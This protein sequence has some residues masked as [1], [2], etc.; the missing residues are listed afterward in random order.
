MAVNKKTDSKAAS[1]STLRG[2]RPVDP[3]TGDTSHGSNAIPYGRFRM[4]RRVDPKTGKPSDEPGTIPYYTFLARRMVDPETGK[5]SDEPDAISYA[6]FNQKRHKEKKRKA[7]KRIPSS[8]RRRDADTASE[9]K[10]KSACKRSV[11][12]KIDIESQ[13]ESYYVHLNEKSVDVDKS[14]MLRWCSNTFD[15]VL[16][17]DLFT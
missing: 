15:V 6:A 4:R 2:R 16:S 14:T 10:D 8:R 17:D 7:L 11:S 9:A 12:R 1:H 13:D 3:K 5:L